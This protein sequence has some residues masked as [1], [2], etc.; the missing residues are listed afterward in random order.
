MCEKIYN[1]IQGE[2]YFFKFEKIDTFLLLYKVFQVF[3]FILT[4]WYKS[5]EKV[6]VIS[7]M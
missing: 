3:L 6:R 1:A 2:K 7:A 4:R 5:V